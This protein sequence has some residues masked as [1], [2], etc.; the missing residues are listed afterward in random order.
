MGGR[1]S[2]DLEWGLQVGPESPAAALGV[3]PLA[4]PAENDVDLDVD[5]QG[6]DEGHVEGDD[7]GVAH[8]RGVGE[9]ALVLVCGEESPRGVG[10][11]CQPLSG[12]RGAM[13]E[14]MTR[15]LRWPGNGRCK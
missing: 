10:E 2:W 14:N 11:G 9:A 3:D 6:D 13:L 4:P 5:Q 7:G 8:A 15:L 12:R 1:G